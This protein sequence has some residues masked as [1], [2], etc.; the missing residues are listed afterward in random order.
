MFRFCSYTFTQLIENDL[1]IFLILAYILKK[2]ILKES[3]TIKY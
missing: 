1:K 2:I 3:G